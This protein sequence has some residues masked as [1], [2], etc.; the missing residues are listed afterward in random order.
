MKT[1]R[2][3]LTISIFSLL[4]GACLTPQPTRYENVDERVEVTRAPAGTVRKKIALVLSAMRHFA[5]ALR[6]S[7]GEDEVF[8]TP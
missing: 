4:G 5:Q 2:A 6:E 3:V 8:M 1:K 7:L